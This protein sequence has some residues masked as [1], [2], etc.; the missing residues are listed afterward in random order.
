[1]LVPPRRRRQECEV[2]GGFGVKD[3]VR[4]SLFFTFIKLLDYW[5][6]HAKVQRKE[7][8]MKLCVGFTLDY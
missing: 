4:K 2:W 6:L 7:F 3:E 8:Q 1:M 5:L